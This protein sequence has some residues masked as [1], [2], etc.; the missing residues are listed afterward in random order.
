MSTKAIMTENYPILINGVEFFFLQNERY[1][2][3]A[4]Y[5]EVLEFGEINTYHTLT[6]SEGISVNIPEVYC[7]LV[8]ELYIQQ[9][10]TM[11]ERFVRE[12]TDPTTNY[13]EAY[14]EM[15]DINI[16]PYCDVDRDSYQERVTP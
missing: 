3:T 7:V 16:N 6:Y 14:N 2:V 10:K 12:N 9:D 8:D 15:L 11:I 13:K 1:D 4:E 5:V